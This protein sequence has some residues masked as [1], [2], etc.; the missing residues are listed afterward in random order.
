MFIEVSIQ[1]KKCL[2]I[3]FYNGTQENINDSEITTLSG[4]KYIKYMIRLHRFQIL[5]ILQ[6]PSTAVRC[7]HK[8]KY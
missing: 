2:E 3:Y 1:N 7:I 4:C 8:Y 5:P 6:V